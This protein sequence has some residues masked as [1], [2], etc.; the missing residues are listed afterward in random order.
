MYL[1]F[2]SVYKTIRFQCASKFSPADIKIGGL[3]EA[4]AAGLKSLVDHQQ[5]VKYKSITLKTS[6][7]ACTARLLP[8]TY[9]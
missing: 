2:N 6:W 8:R 1:I 7:Q 5:S 4:G 9:G 3:G